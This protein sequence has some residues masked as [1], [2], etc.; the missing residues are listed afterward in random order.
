MN[1]SII[2]DD[3]ARSAFNNDEHVI[4][5]EP[6]SAIECEPRR[7]SP[8]ATPFKARSEHVVERRRAFGRAISEA[9]RPVRTRKLPVSMMKAQVDDA[10]H[11]GTCIGKLASAGDGRKFIIIAGCTSRMTLPLRSGNNIEIA[12]SNAPTRK[13]DMTDDGPKRMSLAVA[14]MRAIG[15][16]EAHGGRINGTPSMPKVEGDRHGLGIEVRRAAGA[17][18]ALEPRKKKAPSRARRAVRTPPRG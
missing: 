12:R 18:L 1:T 13:H 14:Q 3:S 2:G 6:M 16:D 10:N 5:D 15:S 9:R 4:R 7:A 11:R 17:R 8:P